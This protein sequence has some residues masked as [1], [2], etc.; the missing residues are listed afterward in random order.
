VAWTSIRW[1]DDG[2][3]RELT[4]ELEVQI[5]LLGGRMPRRV[6]LDGDPLD[7]EV[8]LMLTVQVIEN[9]DASVFDPLADP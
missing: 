1:D 9:V 3:T 6:R 5:P 7:L 2:E 8:Q 4:A